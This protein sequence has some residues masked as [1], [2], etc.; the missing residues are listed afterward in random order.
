MLNTRHTKL[1][2]GDERKSELKFRRPDGDR[3]S[4][5]TS[6]K[7]FVEWSHASTPATIN[8]SRQRGATRRDAAALTGFIR[9]VISYREQPVEEEDGQD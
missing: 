1:R 2:S 8:I 4:R 7:G 9:A 6:P 5:D 3:V